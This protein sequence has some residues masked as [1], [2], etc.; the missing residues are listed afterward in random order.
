MDSCTYVA[1]AAT[2]ARKLR[3]GLGDDTVGDDSA[4]SVLHV[5][6]GVRRAVVAREIVGQRDVVRPVAD[7]GG[8]TDRARP[9][10]QHDG[11][12][13]NPASR[14]RHRVNG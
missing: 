3:L 1:N 2:E 6:G 7:G 14:G 10:Q 8:R 5:D 11:Q 9:G 12:P 4:R 13:Q